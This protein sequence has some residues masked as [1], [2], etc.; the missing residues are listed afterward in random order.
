MFESPAPFTG[1]T[2]HAHASSGRRSLTWTL[3]VKDG[4]TFARNQ[5]VWLWC[6]LT[7]DRAMSGEGVRFQAERRTV[8]LAQRS[9]LTD[10]ARDTLHNTLSA[11]VARYGFDRL[12]SELAAADLA[13]NSTHRAQAVL[14]DRRAAWWREAADLVELWAADRLDF[15]PVEQDPTGRPHRGVRTP[16]DRGNSRE[17]PLASATLNGECVGWLLPQ[18]GVVPGDYPE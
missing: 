13:R 17:T 2:P 5:F 1:I 11:A 18:S 15:K 8:D 3:H 9:Y 4:A 12:W 7:E 10:G 14:A 6:S 16:G